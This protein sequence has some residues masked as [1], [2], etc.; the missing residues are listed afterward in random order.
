MSADPIVILSYARTPMGSFQGSL[1]GASATELGAASVKAAVER[2]GVE[3]QAIDK[4]YMGCVLPAGLGQAPARQAAIK[5][6]LGDHIEATTVNKMCGSGMQAAIMAADTLAAG[7]ADIIIAGGMESMTNA[8]YLSHKH[9]GGARIGHDRLIDHM[10]FDG[11]EDAYEQGRLMGSFAEEAAQSYQ[12]T[13]E[14]QDDYAIASLERAQKA[15]QQGWFDR[16]ITAVEIA[17][18]KGVVTIDRDEQPAKGDAS[19]IPTL[20]PAF[21]KD[22]TITAANASSIS[23]GAAAMLLT[24]Q[25]VA[26]RLGLKPVARITGHAAHAHQ[27]ALFTTAPVGAMQKALDRAGWAIGDVDLFEVNEAFA[28]VAMIAMRDL[29]IP[30]DKINVHGGATALG[31]PIGASGAR[32]MATLL[33]ALQTH[34]GRRGLA[35]LCIGGGEA[36]A[37]A[38]EL[39]E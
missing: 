6:G 8:P 3:A 28:C 11:L 36:T 26:D 16:E 21:A 34:G 32:V 38:V 31:H 22:G 13:R 18:R 35:S 4:I 15:Q 9:R 10:F 29:G 27:P 25:S 39:V 30:H 19:K 2:A 5:A 24:R 37:V 7:S 20:K 12:F 17:G 14:A 33:S 23:D 1:S